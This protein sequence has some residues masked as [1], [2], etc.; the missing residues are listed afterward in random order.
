MPFPAIRRKKGEHKKKEGR[1]TKE[2]TEKEGENK[3]R[4][5]A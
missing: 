4:A 5:A 2:Q 3:K 1:T